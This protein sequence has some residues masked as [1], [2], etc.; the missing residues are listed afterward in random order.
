MVKTSYGILG[1]DI[2]LSDKTCGLKRIST[3]TIIN[4]VNINKIILPKFQRELQEDKVCEIIDEFINIHKNEE[5]FLIKHGYTLSLC[6]IGKLKE[7][8][9]IDGQHRLESMKRLFKQGYNP[10]IIIRIQLCETIND[11][12]KD[13]K[14]LNM[15]SNIPLIYTCFEDEFLQNTLLELKE[16]IKEK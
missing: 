9:L 13:F 10:D 16:L 11:M 8:Y 4:Y 15:N 12:K 5:N 3:E 7:L 6:K 14:L 1:K 2:G